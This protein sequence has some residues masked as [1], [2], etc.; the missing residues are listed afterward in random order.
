MELLGACPK[1]AISTM[2]FY[3]SEPYDPVIPVLFH[4]W[5][6]SGPPPSPI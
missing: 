1:K 2:G 4:P 6:M 5:P 3:F